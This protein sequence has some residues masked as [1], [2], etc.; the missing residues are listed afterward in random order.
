FKPPR[1]AAATAAFARERAMSP[2]VQGDVRKVLSDVDRYGL[3]HRSMMGMTPLMMAVDVGHL[4]L[5]EALVDRGA[6]LDAVDSLGRMP[7][8]FALR[9]AFADETFAGEKLGPLYELV[10]PTAIEIE[11]DG[12]RMRLARNQGEFFLLLCL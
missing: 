3:E 2:Y 12:R 1:S 4:T 11:L 8:H 5:S 7:V 9:R 10:C 6:R